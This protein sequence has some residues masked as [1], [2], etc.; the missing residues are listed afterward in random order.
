MRL[1]VTGDGFLRTNTAAYRCVI[2]EG[3]LARVKKEGDGATPI[4]RFP[5]RRV[6]YRADRLPNPPRTGL[7][8]APISRDDGWCDDP[9]DTQY[10]RPVKLPYV[11]KAER[12]WRND[13]LYDL[14]AVIGYNDSPPEPLRG[15]AIFLHVATPDLEPTEGCIALR[16]ADLQQVIAELAPGSEIEVRAAAD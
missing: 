11:G 10:N 8:S 6:L 3:G 16:L 5:L 7:P 4:G 13:G 15:S 1:I 9:R 2:G 14:L 12:M